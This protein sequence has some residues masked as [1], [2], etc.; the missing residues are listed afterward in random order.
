[1]MSPCY[2]INF[3]PRVLI[4][5]DSDLLIILDGSRL[6]FSKVHCC[7]VKSLLDFR[8]NDLGVVFLHAPSGVWGLACR[9][10]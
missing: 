8:S 9:P 10:P 2:R 1:M 7:V 5:N 4:R 6:L 3:C